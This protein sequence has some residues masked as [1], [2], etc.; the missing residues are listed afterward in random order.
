MRILN[1]WLYVLLAGFVGSVH[2]ADY[3]S[4]S[5]EDLY[6]QFCAACHGVEGR[7]NGPVS[8]S[9]NVEV[10]DLTLIARRNGGTF[11]RDRIEKIIDGRYMLAV[12]G[13]RTMPLW[14]DTFTRSELGNPDAEK[15]TRILT[16]RLADYLWLLQRPDSDA[17]SRATTER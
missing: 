13:T 1:I 17:V 9:L 7:G 10:P 14:G 12:H 6:K 4:R 2:A 16:G 8:K 3:V 11:P 15:A 5:G